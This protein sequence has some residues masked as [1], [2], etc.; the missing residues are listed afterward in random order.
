MVVCVDDSSTEEVFYIKAN[1][2]E[3]IKHLINGGK[4]Q[5]RESD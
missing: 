3:A 2:T 4:I 1:Y 5:S